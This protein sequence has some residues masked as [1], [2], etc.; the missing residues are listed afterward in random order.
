MR[1]RKGA[2]GQDACASRTRARPRL[3]CRLLRSREMHGI[4]RVPRARQQRLAGRPSP[5]HP[6]T[7]GSL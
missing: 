4:H 1:V 2:S 5:R 3:T 7:V 6:A